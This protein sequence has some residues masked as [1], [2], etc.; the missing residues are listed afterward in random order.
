MGG[1][2]LDVA[3]ECLELARGEGEHEPEFLF[4]RR[5]G[6]RP[7]PRH[8]RGR[9]LEKEFRGDTPQ[10]EVSLF[11]FCLAGLEIVSCRKAFFVERI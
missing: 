3:P 5:R 6:C 8:G 7:E 4:P 2:E 10:K 1:I 9:L 11:V